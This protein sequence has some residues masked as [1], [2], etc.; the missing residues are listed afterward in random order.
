MAELIKD[1]DLRR[2]VGGD[3]PGAAIDAEALALA[4]A[5]AIAYVVRHHG[6]LEAWPAD[7]QLGALRLAA[8]LYRD[9]ANPGTT[10]PFGNANVHRRA[11]DI[12]IEQLLEVGRFARPRVG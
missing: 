1:A 2:S 3:T 8:G 7:Y 12:Q 10:D 9:K 5:A 4:K 6:A 11:T